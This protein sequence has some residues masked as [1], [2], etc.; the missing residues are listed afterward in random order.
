MQH[1]KRITW[2]T[3]ANAWKVT[4]AQEKTQ[5]LKQSVAPTCVY[6]DPLTI[7][8][9]HDELVACVFH[10]NVTGDFTEA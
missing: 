3:Y 6:Q 7:A 1:D 4:T 2:E 9:G 8:K 10:T 5:A